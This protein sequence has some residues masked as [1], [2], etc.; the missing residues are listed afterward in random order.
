MSNDEMVMNA[1][2]LQ[3]PARNLKSTIIV[4]LVSTVLVIVLA[5]L[6]IVGSVNLMGI[7]A[8]INWLGTLFMCATSAQIMVGVAWAD[9]PPEFIAKL[10]QPFKGVIITTI[11]FVF[12]YLVMELLIHTVGRGQI[13]P[14]LV[15]CVVQTVCFVPIIMML[16][17]S[18]P[19]TLFTSNST[20]IGIGSVVIA[21][22]LALIAFS[23][24]YNYGF[25]AGEPFYTAVW[26]PAGIF[27]GITALTFSV[28]MIACLLVLTLFEMWPIILIDAAHRQ[29][30][31][32]I[33]SVFLVF[34]VS[35]IV[36]FIFI[37]I[38]KMDPL[39]YMVRIPVSGIFGVFLVENLMQ[40]RL[41]EGVKQPL[42][43]LFKLVACI[44]LAVVMF[45][46]YEW[47][48]P[49]IAGQELLPGPQNAYTKEIWLATAMLAITFPMINILCGALEFWPLVK[50]QNTNSE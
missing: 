23:V 15:H 19:V 33:Y 44:I 26:D 34:S 27:N 22:A 49:F 31:M 17:G 6:F 18:W 30:W 8:Y 37:Q 25:M 47:L 32:G 39:D 35:L 40:F 1:T 20:L 2:G 3:E 29:P 43:G 46:I 28:T 21:Y 41:F 10:E 36:H 5:N 42:K 38:I 13:T 4:G 12:G 48:I 9:Q 14:I 50:S 24:F 7:D 16:F 11:C 45:Q